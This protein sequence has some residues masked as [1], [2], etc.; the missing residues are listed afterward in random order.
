MC[1][2]AGILTS[3][4][5]AGQDLASAADRMVAPLVH[6]GP[7]DA[8][9]WCD[10]HSGIALGFRRLAIV[11]LSPHGHQPMASP[12]RRFVAVF[13]GELYNF[14]ELRRELEPRGYV[15]RGSSDT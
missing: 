12:S 5:L 2:F 6:R 8:G 4:G 3:R 13:N 9:V 7:D 10:P 14:R 15:F 11:D 1:G